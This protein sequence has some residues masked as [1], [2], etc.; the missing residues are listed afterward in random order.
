MPFLFEHFFST[1]SI[2]S[3]SL[4]LH[5]VVRIK[6]GMI[7][8]KETHLRRESR[9]SRK[10]IGRSSSL[11]LYFSHK[12]TTIFA[13]LASFCITISHSSLYCFTS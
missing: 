13:I 11:R 3:S 6:R 7:V 9:M 2:L 5:Q 4:V 1:R 8:T 12:L 10:L